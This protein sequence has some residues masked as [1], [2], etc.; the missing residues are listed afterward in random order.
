MNT[1]LSAFFALLV[2]G[3]LVLSGCSGGNPNIGAAEDAIEAG[4]PDQAIESAQ[5]ALETDSTNAEAYSLIAQ[6]YVLKGDETTDPNQ[7]SEFFTKAREA[8]E[9]AVEMDPSLRGDIQS[10]RQLAYIQEM[11]LGV[12]AFNAARE[13]GDTTDYAK[14]AAYFGGANALEPDSLDAHLNEAYALLNAGQQQ[15]A[16]APLE[17]YVSRADSVGESP[18]TI[19]GQVYLTND[20]PEKAIEVLREGTEQYPENAELQSLML[21]AFNRIDDQERAMSAYREQIERNP[22]N[23]Q[24]RY[25]YGSMLL[26][27][28]R[29]EGAV[30]Q[31]SKAAELDPDNPR[32]FYNLGA[33]YINQAAAID[34][35][36]TTIE[37]RARE[38]DRELTSDEEGT[39]DELVEQRGQQFQSAV[40]PLEKA[41]QLTA[42]G[43]EYRQDICRALFQ[44]YV[45]TDQQEKASQVESCAGMGDSS[46]GSTQ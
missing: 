8:Q 5:T 27:A 19:L 23:A 12:E 25:N 11:R 41:Y 26:T 21:N 39:L 40:Q 15:E 32:I 17:T 38:A 46:N 45:N 2:A 34:D 20:Q 43:D 10:R 1:R 36:I 31:L 24:F 3:L 14:A 4:N 30:E 42:Q 6:A 18:Y 9:K 7:R 35:S 29:Y 28:D 22:E 37:D 33:A 44:A 13:S 16:L